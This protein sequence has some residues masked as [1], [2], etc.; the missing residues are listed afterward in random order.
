[1]SKQTSAAAMNSKGRQL[2]SVTLGHGDPRARSKMSEQENASNI[3]SKSVLKGLKPLK[4]DYAE[5]SLISMRKCLILLGELSANA[6]VFRVWQK[7]YK[8][9]PRSL[10]RFGGIF[11]S[12]IMTFVNPH[13]FGLA[14]ALKSALAVEIQ[15]PSIGNKH[16]LMKS[17]I[18][19]HQ[20]SHELC[21]DTTAL[22]FRQHEQVRIV[23]D[24]VAVRNGVAESDELRAVPS[25]NERVRREQRLVQQ[26]WF[27]R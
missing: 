11:W 22:I 20:S 17:L 8:D 2:R 14:S 3:A 7:A 23:N 26:I 21:A 19:R 10:D 5:L 15:S 27:L 24:Q 6:L 12:V 13:R 18:A 25:C 1:M 9:H 16:V 4:S